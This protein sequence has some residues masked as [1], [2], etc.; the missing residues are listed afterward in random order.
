MSPEY[1]ADREAK[2]GSKSVDEDGPPNIGNAEEVV[3]NVEVQDDTDGL[4]Q[5]HE[6]QLETFP[7][8][9]NQMVWREGQI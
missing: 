3:A 5:P 4:D 6:E 1:E 8:L 9:E 7:L 2:V